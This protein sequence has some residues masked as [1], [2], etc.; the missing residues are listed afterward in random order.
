MEVFTTS[1]PRAQ[2][3]TPMLFTNSE[4]YCFGF[5]PTLRHKYEMCPERFN[6]GCKGKVKNMVKKIPLFFTPCK[7]LFVKYLA[8]TLHIAEL[9]NTLNWYLNFIIQKKHNK[10]IIVAIL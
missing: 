7:V 10:H 4:N 8:S 9:T 6:L 1:G 5:T 3:F 2:G